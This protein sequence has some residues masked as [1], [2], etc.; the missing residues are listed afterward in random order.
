MTD[1]PILDNE[2]AARLSAEVRRLE[3]ALAD[4]QS[5]PPGPDRQAKYA[6]LAA[7]GEEINAY[8]SDAT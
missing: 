6:E 8:F 2:A 3:S 4:Y 7:I 1:Q 5:L